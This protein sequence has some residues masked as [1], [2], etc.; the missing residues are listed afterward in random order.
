MKKKPDNT[1]NEDA[2][3]SEI[4]NLIQSLA[5][6][7]SGAWGTP[8]LQFNLE[9]AFAREDQ[10]F[11]NSDISVY[12]DEKKRKAAID[13]EFA[14]SKLQLN[15]RETL[16][17][18]FS[19]IRAILYHTIQA[20]NAECVD[21]A[22]SNVTAANRYVG[23][24]NGHVRAMQNMADKKTALAKKAASARYAEDYD[25]KV[26]V[27]NFLSKNY[28]NYLSVNE[29]IAAIIREV[30]IGEG[31]AKAWLRSWKKEVGVR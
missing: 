28:H 15:E 12:T 20:Q 3:A 29:I 9:Y 27:Y 14:D 21:F 23:E 6:F 24:F 26:H 19:L 10:A 5:Q 30:P 11:L 1:V 8:W 4:K 13:R 7:S 31:V 22:W 25:L 18:R 2:L 16:A 17:I